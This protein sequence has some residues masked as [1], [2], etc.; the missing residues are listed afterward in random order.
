MCIPAQA[1]GYVSQAWADDT[2][3]D[4]AYAVV[5]KP[6]KDA[7]TGYTLVFQQTDEANSSRGIKVSSYPISPDSPS[8]EWSLF[9]NVNE[10]DQL[11]SIASDAGV[12]LFSVRKLFLYNDQIKNIDLRGLVAPQ[13][14]KIYF[15]GRN[16]RS[17]NMS[18][19]D[20]S[21]LTSMAS[22]FDGCPSLESLDISGFDTSSVEDMRSMFEGC[23]SLKS[24]DVSGFDGARDMSYMFK[25][26]SS[27]TSLDVSGFISNSSTDDSREY[28]FDGC[29]SL[30]S[31]DVSGFTFCGY[32]NIFRGCLSLSELTVCH[33]PAPAGSWSEEWFLYLPHP[34]AHSDRVAVEVINSNTLVPAVKYVFRAASIKPNDS[35]KDAKVTVAPKT[36]SGRILTPSVT[37]KLGGKTLRQGTDYTAS[38]KGGKAVGSYKVTVMGKGSY[39]GTKTTTFQ[40]VPK[41]TSISKLSK[42]KRSFTVKWNKLSKTALEQT[43]GYQVRYSTSK[44]MKDAK[45]KT[46][47]ASSS[48][49]K[50][51]TLKVSKL[52]GGKTYYVQVRTYKKAGNKTYYPSW[53]KAKAVKT[54]K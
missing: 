17:V 14:K 39:T 5:Y 42:A 29:S 22:M 47:K 23:S 11:S 15:A 28:M 18:G 32:E 38:C 6:T 4:T 35:F 40:I 54:T 27:L 21:G 31:L 8:Y 36:Y 51:C 10:K 33:H 26:C 30:K 2:G 12:T 7:T 44:S 52:K 34:M 50:K 13:L 49:G 25:G 46:V 19:F 37:V 53:S 16:L 48:A 3:E 24:L 1:L 41:G 9:D 45:T 43:T 20:T